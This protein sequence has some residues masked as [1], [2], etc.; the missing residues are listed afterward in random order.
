MLQIAGANPSNA[1]TTVPNTHHH[2]S[3]AAPAVPTPELVASFA[4]LRIPVAEPIIENMPPPPCPI[5]N[6]PSEVLAA[7]LKQVAL[8]DPASLSRVALVCR[9][10]AYHVSHDQHIWRR[11]CQG[12]EFGFASMHYSFA[13][14][15]EG[16]RLYTLKA[17]YTPFP[18]GSAAF[19]QI[20]KPLMTWS[21]VFQAFPR[22]RFTGIYI[23]TVNYTRTGM[24]TFQ[25][26]SRSSPIHIV[27][28]YRYLRFYPD[29][30]LIS[31]LGTTKPVD[32]VPYISKESLDIVKDGV[33]AINRHQQHSSLHHPHPHQ[34]SSSSPATSA[35]APGQQSSGNPV[36]PAAASALKKAVRGRWRLAKPLSAET[37][38]ETDAD[39][40]SLEVGPSSMEPPPPPPST[41]RSSS[42]IPR[43]DKYVPTSS[44]SAQDTGPDLH[45]LLVETEGADQKY[46]YT[47]H[48]VLRSSVA[49][50]PSNSSKNTKLAWKGFWSYNHLTDDWAEF[51]LR[52]DRAFVFRR[53]RGWG[54]S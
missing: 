52:N 21:Q 50:N 8:L 54:T 13:C 43:G 47:M 4:R 5:S 34:P 37:E 42:G 49:G 23:S 19:L 24:T 36:P 11:L 7:I 14:D 16:N 18:F 10:L 32:V 38:S 6:V 33:P 15:V 17:R 53:V 25:G 46:T 45:D 12:P 29:G 44:N 28:Y 1:S 31:L 35:E 30:S 27:T 51:G 40:S 48:L 22:I 41:F 9:R 20:P 39:S 26:S 3:E 2:S